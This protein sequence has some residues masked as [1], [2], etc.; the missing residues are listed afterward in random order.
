MMSL[1][2]LH[3]VPCGRVGAVV[4]AWGL[5]GSPSVAQA[6]SMKEAATWKSVSQCTSVLEVD[7]YLKSFPEGVYVPDARDCLMDLAHRKPPV[8]FTDGCDGCP[9]LV[10]IPPGTFSMGSKGEARNKKQR[11]REE[12]R[13]EVEI[14]VPIAVGIYEVT[15][16]EFRRFV[17]ETKYRTEDVCYA[18]NLQTGA[19]V[20]PRKGYSWEKPGF[21]QTDSHPVVCVSFDDALAYLDWLIERTGAEYR[22]LSES[23]WEYAARAGTR[24]ARYWGSQPTQQCTYENGLDMTFKKHHS[25]N[26]KVRNWRPVRCSDGHA[27]TAPVGSFGNPNGFGL[28]DMLGNAREWVEDCW[29]PNYEDAPNDGIAWT[30]GGNCNARVVRGGSWAN[31]PIVLRSA[32][33][34]AWCTVC[35][36]Y[37]TTRSDVISFRVARSLHW[38]N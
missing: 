6:Q 4:L 37:D 15:R 27:Y 23:E 25:A 13:H 16:G 2:A 28:H 9:E 3:A 26:R 30:Y 31:F 38:G 10:L 34:I 21:E 5:L 17:E 24:T 33:R 7:F 1:P 8:R 36:E 11:R 18:L 14:E 20:P 22:L 32:M 12:P 35:V 19:W 29:N